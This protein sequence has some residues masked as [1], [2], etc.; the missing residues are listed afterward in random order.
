MLIAIFA[1]FA[2]DVLGVISGE[3]MPPPVISLVRLQTKKLA[4]VPAMAAMRIQILI[5]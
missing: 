4:G 3:R 5:I 1:V 2:A